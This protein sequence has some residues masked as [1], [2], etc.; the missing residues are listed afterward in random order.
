MNAGPRIPFTVPHVRENGCTECPAEEGEQGYQGS[1][2]RSGPVHGDGEEAG[3]EDPGAADHDIF[4]HR[5]ILQSAVMESAWKQT[6]AVQNSGDERK[7]G[8]EE[9]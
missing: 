7:C 6:H 1:E 9:S 2:I 4:H 8:D 5:D 3:E